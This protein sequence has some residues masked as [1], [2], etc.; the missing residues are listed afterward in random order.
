M[1]KRWDKS[2]LASFRKAERKVTCYNPD[3]QAVF[4]RPVRNGFAVCYKCRAKFWIGR[5]NTLGNWRFG[6]ADDEMWTSE[7]VDF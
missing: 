5:G 7:G 4:R 3:C 6:D 1:K 2:I